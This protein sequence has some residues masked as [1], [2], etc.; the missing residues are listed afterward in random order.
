MIAKYFKHGD[1]DISIDTAH[2][3]FPANKDDKPAKYINIDKDDKLF[4]IVPKDKE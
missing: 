1:K 4:K 3:Y 2:N